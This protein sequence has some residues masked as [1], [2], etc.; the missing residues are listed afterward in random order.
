[1]P[2]PQKTGFLFLLCFLGLCASHADHD[3]W[4]LLN[5]GRS[6][7]KG[8]GFLWNDVFAYVPVKS[9][10]IFHEWLAG[11]VFYPLYTRMGAWSLQLLRYAL[12][13]GAIF[14]CL[15]LAAAR[16]EKE[17]GK[18]PEPGDTPGAPPSFKY[19]TWC[20]LCGA[21][22]MYPGFSPGRAQAFTYFF[23]ALLL[24]VLERAQE[25]KKRALFLLP[26]LF[27]LWANLHGGFA[28]GLV[29]FALYCVGS[30]L[31][32][33]PWRAQGLVFLSCIVAVAVNPYGIRLP[34]AVLGHS[35]SPQPEVP[36]WYSLWQCITDG[37]YLSAV[38]LFLV[39]FAASAILMSRTGM[40]DLPEILVSCAALVLGVL[41]VRHL[42][43]FGVC[44]AAYAPAWAQRLPGPQGL[45]RRLRA[46]AVAFSLCVVFL[47]APYWI[48][49]AMH[50]LFPRLLGNPLSI[51]ADSCEKMEA[52]ACYPIGAVSFLKENALGGKMLCQYEWGSFISW[53]FYPEVTVAMDSRCET[54]YPED[55]RTAYFDFL[56]SRPGEGAF[57]SLYP[58]D[59]VLIRANTQVHAF[60]ASRRDFTEVYRDGLAVLFSRDN[61][62]RQVETVRLAPSE[63]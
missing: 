1:M 62:G 58:P 55:V 11:V 53:V 54:V 29:F 43:F 28:A 15:A 8:P 7:W 44:F 40:D 59:L 13:L 5:F 12:G 47:S 46:A 20:L 36:E 14:C 57:L 18:T 39:S 51:R 45:T 37:E 33:R 16:M 10:W 56:L 32:K 27:C 23:F 38:F 25:D 49:G 35:L 34:L 42:P 30:V 50:V 2:R 19:I 4:G 22:L 9:P 3:L 52:P 21:C 6:F 26:P 63:R 48:R 24:L 17:S 41:H 31:A 61:A 60:M